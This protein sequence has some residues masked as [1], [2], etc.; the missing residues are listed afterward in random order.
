MLQPHDARDEGLLFMWKSIKLLLLWLCQVKKQKDWAY[1]CAWIS[2][3]ILA[4][5][6]ALPPFLFLFALSFMQAICLCWLGDVQRSCLVSSC[7]STV[8]CCVTLVLLLYREHL[9]VEALT[10]TLHLYLMH[11]DLCR[12]STSSSLSASDRSEISNPSSLQNPCVE[13]FIASNGT[14]FCVHQ[15][16]LDK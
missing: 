4:R 5:D 12:S 10:C 15:L 2:N 6:D 11:F 1:F 16:N 8:T 14:L 13:G 7:F 9:Q 3:F